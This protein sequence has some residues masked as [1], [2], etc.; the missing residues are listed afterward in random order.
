MHTFPSVLSNEATVLAEAA[1]YRLDIIGIL[2]TN[3]AYIP[4]ITHFIPLTLI[5]YIAAPAT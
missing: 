3:N 2:V 4:C 5:I 1:A